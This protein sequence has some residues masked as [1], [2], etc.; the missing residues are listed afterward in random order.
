VRGAG[1]PG[2]GR[3]FLVIR[4]MSHIVD[5]HLVNITKAL[6]P[7]GLTAPMWR[8]LNGLVE[9][10]D[11]TVGDLARHTAF[12]RSYVSRLVSRMAEL[13]L[14]QAAGDESDRRFRNVTLTDEGRARQAA[15]VGV[16]QRLNQ[17]SLKGLSEAEVR[18]LN[19]LVDKVALNIGA[20]RPK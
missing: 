4:R 15:A 20:D 16:V 9:G 1:A 17:D 3:L 6:R 11:A 10:G 2:E 7:H 12:E 13:G 19:R 8:V 14:V 5:R 18:T